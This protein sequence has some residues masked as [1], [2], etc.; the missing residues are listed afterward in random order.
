MLRSDDRKRRRNDAKTKTV[1][2]V[3]VPRMS[4][5]VRLDRRRSGAVGPTITHPMVHRVSFPRVNVRGI[6]KITILPLVTLNSLCL[7][8][9][10]RLSIHWGE[11]GKN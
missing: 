7:L 3:W 8:D 6:C 11:K 5:L 10:T 1:R 2:R 9:Y 4:R